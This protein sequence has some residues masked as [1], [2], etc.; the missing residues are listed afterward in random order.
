[1]AIVDVYDAA[2]TRA[3]YRRPMSHDAAVDFIVT[4]TGTHFDPAVVE[5]FVR[6]APVFKGLSEESIAQLAHARI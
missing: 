6:V 5:A 3:L 4:G 1:M 2:V